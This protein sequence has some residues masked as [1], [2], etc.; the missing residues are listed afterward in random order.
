MQ[1]L[2][3]GECATD[4]LSPWPGVAQP[5]ERMDHDEFMRRLL[6]FQPVEHDA[7][8]T[9]VGE[10]YLRRTRSLD[11]WTRATSIAS[12]E[13]GGL[14]RVFNAMLRAQR[15]AAAP[16]PRPSGIFSKSTFASTPTTMAGTAPW[17]AI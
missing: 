6:A 16:E 13:D 4:N 9:L 7:Y 17:P 2:R 11:D 15:L 10:A 3:A 12:Y 8:L 1:E 5:G 14:S